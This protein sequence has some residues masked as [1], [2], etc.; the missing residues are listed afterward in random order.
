MS[1]VATT[2]TKLNHTK[3]TS[4]KHRRSKVTVNC[5]SKRTACSHNSFEGWQSTYS[6]RDVG[7]RAGKLRQVK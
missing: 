2:K 5:R 6:K 3:N 4:S 1:P 7:K